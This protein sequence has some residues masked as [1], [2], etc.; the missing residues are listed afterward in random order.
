M[1]IHI[2]MDYFTVVEM[3]SEFLLLN[4]AESIVNLLR[5]SISST[6]ADW[7]RQCMSTS[8]V[9]QSRSGL[10]HVRHYLNIYPGAVSAP[11]TNVSTYVPAQAMLLLLSITIYA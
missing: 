11:A 5:K 10:F 9:P 6:D 7:H 1:E 2:Q 3:R 8:Q 4:T